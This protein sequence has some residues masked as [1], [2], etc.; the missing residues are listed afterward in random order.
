MPAI[1]G[2]EMLAAISVCASR[3]GVRGHNFGVGWSSRS[4]RR[5][6]LRDGMLRVLWTDQC[7]LD[8][9]GRRRDR[10]AEQ[11]G[12]FGSG[13]WYWRRLDWTMESA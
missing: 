5:S 2:F 11:P 9:M 7:P 12:T 8:L 1:G 3:A 13:I 10:V 4:V 6:R